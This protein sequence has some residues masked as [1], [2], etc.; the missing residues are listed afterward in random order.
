VFTDDR[1]AKHRWPLLFFALWWSIHI[2]QL[3]PP[4]AL[5]RL[6]DG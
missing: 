2:E 1:H 5:A 3:A 6:V 4:E